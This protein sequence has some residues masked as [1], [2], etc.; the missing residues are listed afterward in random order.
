MWNEP[1]RRWTYSRI[2]KIKEDFKLEDIEY[3]LR[4][5]WDKEIKFA[6]CLKL[7]LLKH[8]LIAVESNDFLDKKHLWRLFKDFIFNLENANENL[9]I[10][11]QTEFWERQLKRVKECFLLNLQEYLCICIMNATFRW[12]R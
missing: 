2:G 4:C 9:R 11:I 8:K 12:I 6:K 10:K 7:D 5:I 3:R 1:T